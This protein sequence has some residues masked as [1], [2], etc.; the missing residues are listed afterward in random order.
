MAVPTALSPACA[1]PRDL[2]GR[3]GR[4]GT[5]LARHGQVGLLHLQHPGLIWDPVHRQ[6]G[7]L[8]RVRA[9]S[10]CREGTCFAIAATP[11]LSLTFMS[12]RANRGFTHKDVRASVPLR[13]ASFISRS[14]TSPPVPRVALASVSA[15][16]ACTFRA[17]PAPTPG[18]SIPIPSRGQPSRSAGTGGGTR[19][20][21]FSSRSPLGPPFP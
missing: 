18:G 1:A 20:G 9:G 10:E 5:A 19:W 7:L 15:L 4:L 8:H 12:S 6:K 14:R 21:P 11:D 2:A 17:R 13:R 3:T 16:P